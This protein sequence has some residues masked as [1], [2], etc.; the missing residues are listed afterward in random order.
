MNKIKITK[1]IQICF[2]NAHE[3]NWEEQ[4]RSKENLKNKGYEVEE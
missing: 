2:F 3:S 4:I 1:D